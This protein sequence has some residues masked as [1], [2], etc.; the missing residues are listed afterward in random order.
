MCFK[1]IYYLTHIK[2]IN[3]QDSCNSLFKMGSNDCYG[4]TIELKTSAI[5]ALIAKTK[6]DLMTAILL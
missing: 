1:L 6:F 5:L 3:W 2:E 4:I